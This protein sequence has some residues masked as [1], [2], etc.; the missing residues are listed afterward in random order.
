MDD[1]IVHHL[2]PLA[3]GGADDLTNTI[4]L[5]GTCHH[6]WHRCCEG[7]VSFD[8]FMSE[9]QKVDRPAHSTRTK[10]A[11]RAAKARGQRLG[12]PNGANALR[13]AGKGNSAALETITAKADAHAHDLAPVIADIRGQGVSSL[14]GIAAALNARAIRTPRGGRWYAASVRNLLVRLEPNGVGIF[15]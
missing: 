4:T 8:T 14:N 7:W 9:A 3:D 1:L 10:E 11:L 13:R 6:G 2:C 15:L 12:N 5:C